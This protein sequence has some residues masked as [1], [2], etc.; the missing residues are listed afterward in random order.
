MLFGCVASTVT[1]VSSCPE[2]LDTVWPFARV[3]RN[4]AAIGAATP[5]NEIAE[6]PF[7]SIDVQ[8]R[9]IWALH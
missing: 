4:N 6:T 1:G 5:A 3:T 7:G 2:A 9:K 8:L